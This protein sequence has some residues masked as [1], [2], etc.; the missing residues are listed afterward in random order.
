MGLWPTPSFSEIKTATEFEGI[1]PLWM[2]TQN[3]QS[4]LFEWAKILSL[5]F[6]ATSITSRMSFGHESML[7]KL[8]RNFVTLRI[9]EIASNK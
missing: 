9:R 1:S 2:P 6:N 3:T 8:L 4:T 5:P 7:R